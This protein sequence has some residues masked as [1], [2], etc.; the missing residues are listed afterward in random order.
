MGVVGKYR[1]FYLTGYNGVMRARLLV[2]LI[3]PV[4]FF[5]L[6][7]EASA[8]STFFGP[9]VP[10]ECNC[11]PEGGIS[12]DGVTV[13][14]SA[15]DYGC[16]LQTVQNATNFAVSMGAIMVVVAIAYAGALLML[17]PTNPGNREMARGAV[18]KAVVGLLVL[19][20]AWLIV[21]FVM[22]MVYNADAMAGNVSLGPWNAILNEGNAPKC[23][24]PR[25][26]DKLPSVFI[27]PTTVGAYT[28]N[29]PTRPSS[30]GTCQ[31]PTTGN[32]SPAALSMF[33]AAA[34]QASQ[35][36]F[37]ESKGV[38]RS[39]SRTDV[40]RNDPGRRAFSFGLFQINITYHNVSGLPC[41]TAFNG[42]NYTATVKNE[43]LYARCVAAAQTVEGNIG[44]A[45]AT[46]R[47]TGWREWSTARPCGLAFVDDG[48]RLALGNLVACHA[49]PIAILHTTI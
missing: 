10:P 35:I 23:I 21:D 49:D 47:R 3:L 29:T 45:L 40:M 5:M 22:K 8:A 37:A 44:E 9:I 27:P 25:V 28:P 48:T 16:V 41:P 24:A 31:V 30:T 18:M 11:E 1:L 6:P 12:G 38:I 4:L 13:Q 20:S 14:A 17:T 46:Y 39:V 7:T 36:C 19:L 32:C 34:E 43:A 33:G 15:A 26:A 2:L 42:H